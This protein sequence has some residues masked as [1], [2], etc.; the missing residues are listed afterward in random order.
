MY[1]VDF[2]K[3]VDLAAFVLLLLH[4]LR[5]ALPLALLNGVG[6]L[7]GPASP[8]VSFPHIIT[9]VT[10]PVKKNPPSRAVSVHKHQKPPSSKETPLCFT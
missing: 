1:L 3:A 9:G 6:V 8:S 5:E 4:F 10:T 7:E 2:K